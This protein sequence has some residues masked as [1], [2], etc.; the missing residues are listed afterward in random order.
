MRA[1]L[2]VDLGAIARNWQR[3]DDLSASATETAAV[4]KADGYGL[5]AAEIAASLQRLGVRTFFVALAEEGSRVRD[6]I[7]GDAE[8]F[9][10]SGYLAADGPLIAGAGLIPLIN[11]VGQFRDFAAD[12]PGHPPALQ[13]DTGMNRLGLE[14]DEFRSVRDSLGTAPPC[15]VMSHLAC[16]DDPHDPLNLQQLACFRELTAGMDCRLSLAATGGILLGEA[17]HFDL[18]RAGIGIY[19]GL[20]FADGEGVVELDIPVIQ[21]RR[22]QPGEIVGYGATWTAQDPTRVATLSAGYAD[23]IFRLLGDRI[24]FH[25]SGVPC[26]GLGRISMDLITVDVSHL[27][28]PPNRLQ[29]LGEY[30]SI[31]NLAELA[32]TIGYEVLT[33]LGGRY[34]RTYKRP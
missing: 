24:R 2:T 9:V 7:G 25:A 19:G 1:E 20:P 23:G 11:S 4:I 31:D 12:F 3:L 22:V 15:L 13:L 18:C 17:Y 5:G 14:A 21:T 6:A 34:D 32:S 33:S 27:E 26:P 29:L 16:A 30:Q 28:E 8:I 10:L